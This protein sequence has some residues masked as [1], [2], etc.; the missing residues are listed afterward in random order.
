M[1][2]IEKLKHFKR[3]KKNVDYLLVKDNT[4][5]EWFYECTRVWNGNFRIFYR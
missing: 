4:L 3:N 1:N 2:Q 5:K